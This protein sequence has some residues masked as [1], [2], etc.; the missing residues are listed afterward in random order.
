MKQI[1]L[2][3]I[4]F[5]GWL[6]FS[7]AQRDC[8]LPAEFPHS[9]STYVQAAGISGINYIADDVSCSCLQIEGGSWWF[10][11]TCTAS[12]T[13]EFI[14]SPL[15]LGEEYDF[16]LWEGSCP[17]APDGP[18]GP[19]PLLVAC[20]A[21]SDPA[22]HNAGIASNSLASFGVPNVGQFEPTVNLIAGNKYYLLMTNTSNSISN[23]SLTVG[24][25][26]SW[27][28]IEPPN[29]LEG[30][31]EVC[32]GGEATF[33]IPDMPGYEYNWWVTPGIST[34]QS[35]D[36]VQ[37]FNFPPFPNV[38][39]FQVCVSL[40]GPPLACSTGLYC[41]DI[42]VN[43]IPNPA[44][45]EYGYVCTNDFYIASNGQVFYYGGVFHWVSQSWQG[46]DSITEL[47]LTQ[48]VSD[49][50]FIV[51]T[52]CE[53]DCI[54]FDGNT[55]CDG[56]TYDQ[57]LQNQYGCDS[58]TTLLLVVV[59]V[60]TIITG[61]GTLNCSTTSL[62][63]SGSTSIYG[64][65]P[66]YTWKKGNVVVGSSPTL[67][68]TTGGTYTLTIVS[69]VG[70]H[71]CV[72]ESTVVIVQDTAPPQN[73]VATGGSIN[74]NTA[75]VMLM[76]SSTTAG[77]SYLWTGPNGFSSNLQNP[78]VS[79]PGNYLLTVTGTN[80]CTKTDMA[81]VVADTVKPDAAAA[82]NGTLNCN[83]M[84][85]QLNGAGS[86]TGSDFAYLWTTSN[87]FI[88][89]D[90]TTLTPTVTQDGDYLLTVTNLTN[91]CTST[92][93]TTVVQLPPVSTQITGTTDVTCFGDQSGSTT[94]SASGGDGNF[95]YE[96]S[97]G[98]TTATAP[99]LLAGDYSVIVT[100]GNG[101]S[102][103]QSVTIVQ[104][105]NLLVNAS[106]TPQTLFNVNDGTAMA[107]PT[108][109]TGSYTYLWSNGESTQAI[110]DLAP[111]D[112]TV[113]VTDEAG[114]QSEQTVTVFQ[115]NCGVPAS[116]QATDISC[117]GGSDGE[118][119]VSLQGGILPDNVE[120]SNGEAGVTISG[121]SAGMYIA[122]VTYNAGCTAFAEV[123]L[124]EPDALGID[125]VEMVATTCGASDGSLT[126]AGTGGTA[127]YNY[128]WQNGET[129]A[130]ISGLLAGEYTVVITDAN[131]CSD[132]FNVLVGTNLDLPPTVV[133]QNI[134]LMLDDNGQVIANPVDVDNGSTDD[135]DI[136]AYNLDQT[137]FDCD[138][139]GDN[140]VTL[141]VTDSGNNTATGTAIVTILDNLPPVL[142]LQSISVS[143]DASGVATITPQMLDDGS[144]DNCGIVEWTLSQESFDC[145]NAGLNNV[146]VT[147]A[148]ASGNTSTASVAITITESTPPQIDC[149]SNMVVPYC[150]PVGIFDVTA[151]DNCAGSVTL[152]Q[153]SG[154]PSGSTFPVGTNTVAFT[155][156]DVSGNVSNCS[157]EITVP[158]MISAN[159]T[160]VPATCFG[161]N[162]GSATAVPSGGSQ[163]YTYLWS[164]GDNTSSTNGL[165]AGQYSVSITDAGGCT[166]EQSVTIGQPDNLTTILVAIVNDSIN[167]S[168]GSIDV[169]VSGGVMPYTF[170]WKNAMTGAV[171]GN[172]E[173]IS[174]LP[175]GTY[176]LVATD[177]NGCVTQSGYTIQ[178]MNAVTETDLESHILLYPN[179]TSGQV[180]LELIGLNN[181]DKVEVNAFDVT[182]RRVLQSSSTS[183]KQLLN[184]KD[185]PSGVYLLKI[186]IGDEVLSKRLVVNR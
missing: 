172:M 89:A 163:P 81:L 34:F 70:D 6:Q 11:F 110:S 117:N 39:T 27:T 178:N 120:W 98:A 47:Q 127:G 167:Q 114:C 13:L 157:F 92:A 174:G 140:S 45:Y 164:N 134:T 49:Q 41:R 19:L 107:N 126:V 87:G 31:S 177:A 176:T 35:T 5:L 113:V 175:A 133:T 144:T 186:M 142:N 58:T 99:D 23:F 109:G 71:T 125:V 160:T 181:L 51:E 182:G 3:P 111:D 73:V 147:A 48:V 85:L 78:T 143:I 135:C 148:D 12:G 158:M 83:A 183:T 153:I 121:L 95:T 96:W 36:P 146:E 161:A 24:G 22:I 100:D 118:A 55:I 162:D 52:V 97:S 57:V 139:L 154:L 156:T 184:F 64:D 9:G 102:S 33:S 17:C 150:D 38:S 69:T 93:T 15:I 132:N 101:C 16:A 131:G 2:S 138:D 65:N 30:P 10:G 104:P 79:T 151:T 149:P 94:V 4:F 68:V 165:I 42:T 145:N 60:E 26:A 166:F 53:G 185:K 168:I 116:I 62:Q 25:T 7:Q 91:G 77:V 32:L 119:T 54:V 44:S 21:F 8:C 106:A 67:T 155:A 37:T 129:T 90:E 56:G 20:N 152:T 137:T 159:I 63:L 122:T 1:L 61:A 80:T 179:P 72:D 88:S 18:G 66:V 40:I 124:A 169:T 173:D 112:Y 108:G 50:K 84:S 105:P 130:S 75:Q 59:P 86:S 29:L 128:L 43:P 28:R 115:Y 103:M 74:C 180:T 170:V 46:C 76:G 141:T 14:V 82:T 123:T 136:V 171:I